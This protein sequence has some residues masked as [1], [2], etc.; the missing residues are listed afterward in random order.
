MTDLQQMTLLLTGKQLS[1]A[2][3]EVFQSSPTTFAPATDAPVDTDYVM[4]PGDEVVLHIWGHNAFSG[5][6]TVDRSGNIYIP[7]V[8]AIRVAGDSFSEAQKKVDHELHRT[9]RNFDF[10][11]NLGKLRSIQIFVLGQASRPGSYTVSGLSTVLNALL[12]SGGPNNRGSVRN[13]ELRRAGKTVTTI[14]LYDILLRGNRTSDVQLQSGD[15]LFIPYTGPQVAVVGAVRDQAIYE[16]R[17]GESL[18]SLLQLAGGVTSTGNEEKITI[19]RIDGTQGSTTLNVAL[20]TIPKPLDLHDS[21]VVQVGNVLAGMRNTVT[22]RGNLATPGRFRW[23]PGMKLSDIIPEREALLTQDYWHVRELEGRP[24]PLFQPILVRPGTQIRDPYLPRP[25]PLRPNSLEQTVPGQT[26]TQRTF[27]YDSQ[28][29]PQQYT[30]PYE[31]T[32][33]DTVIGTG[34]GVAISQNDQPLGPNQM[35]NYLQMRTQQQARPT[36]SASTLA[37]QQQQSAGSQFS[38][39]ARAKVK[40]LIPVAE[41]DWTYAVIERLDPVTLRTSLIPFN[42][43]HLVIDHDPTQNLPLLPGDVV[44]ILSQADVHVAIEQQTKYVRIEGEVASA[45]VYSVG[46]NESLAD[47]VRRA[48]G[49]T[50]KAYLYGSSFTRENARVSQQERLDEYIS[51]LSLQYAHAEANR[52]TGSTPATES[53]DIAANSADQATLQQLRQLRATGRVV[54]EFGPQSAG[55]DAIPAL[56]LENGDTFFVP[57]KPITVSVVGAVNGQN[58]FLYSPAR[59]VRD[60][61]NLAGQFTPDANRSRAF[62]IRADGSVTSSK[63]LKSGLWSDQFAS[64]RLSPGDTIIVPEKPARA[65]T[66][67]SIIDW[68]QLFSQF[69]LGAIAI[70]N[71]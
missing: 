14:D 17:E 68:S 56:P 67:R 16:I 23:T 30:P 65:P 9:Y 34:A 60:Y 1:V 33:T 7:D 58:V 28:S 31:D 70:K 2:G 54:L 71:L 38:S 61:L 35:Q 36:A 11:L 26:Q 55:N 50:A 20:K 39:T 63:S 45:G 24:T 44:T 18:Q 51:Q 69:A 22:I 47:V 25:Q 52:A 43:G 3:R 10:S 42:L 21:D 46:P 13:V 27:P 37:E 6:L 62:V 19:S 5:R 29:E 15:V 66:L 53:T 49:L 59:R 41:I 12:V 8:G 32:Q 57:S 64:L 40:I 48:G 4:G